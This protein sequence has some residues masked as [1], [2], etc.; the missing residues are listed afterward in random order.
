[1]SPRAGYA[2]FSIN[3]FMAAMLALYIS[4]SIGLPRPY[5]AM[6]TVY[7]TV[8]PLTG[9]LRS[10]AVYRFFGTLAGG[11]AA[12]VIVPTFVGA[13]EMMTLVMAAWTGLCLY[14]SLLDRTPRAYVF[15]LAGYT[16]AIIGFPAVTAPQAI[17]E[18]ALARVEEISL[19]I[20]CA[21][22]VHTIV[23]PRDVARTLSGRIDMVLRDSQTW[24]ADALAGRRGPA[25]REERRRIAAD[26]TELQ[27][28]S[29]HLPFDTANLPLRMDTVRAL[30]NRLSY[31]LPLTTAIED[32]LAQIGKPTRSLSRLLADVAAWAE[33]DDAPLHRMAVAA[34]LRARCR[35]LAPVVGDGEADWEALLTTSLLARLEELIQA[36]QD[37]RELVDAI[38]APGG[39]VSGRVAELM[40]RPPRRPLHLDHGM[41]ALSGLA[42]MVAVTACCALW[43][44]AAWPEG[45][46]AATFAAIM[47]S[48]FAAQDDPAP[49]MVS[50]L[51]MSIISIPFAALYLFAIL[52]AVDGF[53]MLALALAPAL[54]TLSYLQARPKSAGA[55]IALILGFVGALNLQATFSADFPQFLNGSLALEAGIAIALAVTRLLRS[56]G[57][58]WAAKRILKR[59]WREV[60]ALARHPRDI[61]ADA[62]TSAMLDRLGLIS[63]RVALAGPEDAVDAHEALADMRVGLNLLDL[64][65]SMGVVGAGPGRSLQEVLS[66]VGG[67]FE[68]RLAGHSIDAEI[69]LLGAIDRAIDHLASLPMERAPL[70]G[71]TALTGIR[72][73]LFPQA[74]PYAPAGAIA[75]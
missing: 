33:G 10:K 3:T 72:R 55:G 2:L 65:A 14:L 1:M 51:V 24:I 7:I 30:E 42:L 53:P 37:S 50:F 9:A 70:R 34:R 58:G 16:A 6:L 43:I 63:A 41:A 67:A 45:A 66:G 20:F 69:G 64:H 48:F 22:L 25:E 59:G 47:S 62:W 36:F 54:L 8:Q 57:A 31:M 26:I 19:G 40:R 23:F 4:F 17:F 28:T 12:V 46:A 52:P 49:A 35:A 32:R 15:M 18:T 5:W 71:F 27:L 75:P 60:V 29:S 38:H 21:T 11:V 68:R 39:R 56:V 61:D 74:A 73:N 44:F 13:P